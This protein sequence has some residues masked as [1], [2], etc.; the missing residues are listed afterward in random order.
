MGKMTKEGTWE[1]Q[2]YTINDKTREVRFVTDDVAI[3]GYTVNERV[4]DDGK[5]MQLEANDSSVWMRRDGERRCALLSPVA[6]DVIPAVAIVYPAPLDPAMA[7]V[8]T[9]PSTW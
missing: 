9:H 8:G 2:H 4:V 6:L 5:T 7:A 1:L 3:I